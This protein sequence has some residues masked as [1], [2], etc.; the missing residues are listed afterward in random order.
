MSVA[1]YEQALPVLEAADLKNT[2]S[3]QPSWKKELDRRGVPTNG[4]YRVTAIDTVDP[5]K[6]SDLALRG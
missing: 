6:P 4:L 2:H 3:S 5:L 1:Q